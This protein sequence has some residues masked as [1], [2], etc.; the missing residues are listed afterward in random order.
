MSQISK[1]VADKMIAISTRMFLYD[2]VV[3]FLLIL[4][5]FTFR[6]SSVV[7]FQKHP[8]LATNLS[9]FLTLTVMALQLIAAML[10][11][12]ALLRNLTEYSDTPLNLLFNWG[13]ETLKFTFIYSIFSA[14]CCAKL[15]LLLAKC[16]SNT[17]ADYVQL[18]SDRLVKT[19][20]LDLFEISG[21]SITKCTH[22]T[23][24][25]IGVI[26]V[27]VYH[28]VISLMLAPLLFEIIKRKFVVSYLSSLKEQ[29]HNFPHSATDL[30]RLD[31]DQTKKRKAR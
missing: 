8:E 10:S 21:I 12:Y 23:G 30:S 13:G 27:I 6:F 1:K 31:A 20:T 3:W 9:I 14:A 24:D 25:S 2:S 11:N 28:L 22:T 15:G 19:M 26:M 18:F 16:N 17:L 29:E 7:N 4:D 5:S